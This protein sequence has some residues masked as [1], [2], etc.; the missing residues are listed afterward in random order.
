MWKTNE[1]ISE[2]KQICG[3]P[4]TNVENQ[5]K[6]GE[7]IAFPPPRLTL[8]FL[9]FINIQSILYTSSSYLINIQSILIYAFLIFINIQTIFIH[10][11]SFQTIL[12]MFP[13]FKPFYTR[14][15]ISN[16]FIHVFLI[17]LIFINIRYILY[18]FSSFQ[19]ILYTFSS[20]G[21]RV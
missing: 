11:S 21:K 3:N 20:W 14:F 8:L 13:H 7:T 16:H 17:F 10:V 9:V 5:V 12:Y 18:T 19:T 1:I 15:L 4:N 2:T 6:C